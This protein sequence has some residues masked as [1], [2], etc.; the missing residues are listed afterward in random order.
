MSSQAKSKVQ[1]EVK[2]RR[3]RVA[4]EPCRE[5]KRKCNAEEP[6]NTCTHWDYDCYY[7]HEPRRKRIHQETP[8]EV[9]PGPSNTPGVVRR[10]EANSGAAFVH[11]MGLKIDPA[12]AP[13]LSLFGW[14]I[15][16]RPLSSQ[17]ANLTAATSITEITSL[18]HMKT[19]AKIY[20]DKLHPCY[21]FID[22]SQFFERLS[23]R[24]ES[25]LAS[26]LYDCVL[27]GVAALGCL[28]S[29]RD[30]TMT[31]THLVAFACS[32]L[33]LHVLTGVPPVD[34]LTGWTLRVIYMRMTDLPHATWMASSKL[35]HLIEAAGFHLESADSV[36]PR[37]NTT[38]CDP[39]IRRRLFGVAQ[40]LNMWT[41]YDLGLSR[42]SFQNND[43]PLLPSVKP[44]DFTHEVLGLLPV[45]ASL[46]PGKSKE[47][48]VDLEATLSKT[49]DRIH[50]EPPSVMAQCNL[51]LCILRRIHSQNFDISSQLAERVL[52]LF[53]RGLNCSRTMVTNCT[54]W[55]QMANVPFQIICVLLVM[56][57]RP[58]L[59]MLP[60]AMQT[61][62]LVASTYDTD[63]MK[64]ACKA[65]RLLVKL[66]QQ[67]RKDD[68]AI[69]NQSLE[70]EKQESPPEPSTQE[71]PS[72]EEY[73]WL[74]ALVADLPG[75]QKVDLDQFLNADMM[76]GSSL[77]GGSE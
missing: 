36:F 7:T 53:K 10:L 69:F 49:I 13:R 38:D 55:H 64:E 44:G 51:A 32:T 67:R 4:C 52:D 59:S 75:L 5:R 21:G 58:S 29:Q 71:N 30:M 39:D 72:S 27:G 15:G 56:D 24:W 18:G 28:F 46:D 37:S 70:L 9:T 48:E 26:G 40:H 57:T 2:R 16:K 11:K 74:G 65:A 77:L 1:S 17:I 35:M 25:P 50:N 33:E 34:L 22:R 20:F 6:C 43:L 60:E 66:H 14:N 23:A 73:S 31:E 41:S 47:D 54:P 68:I 61:L 62:N 8:V 12:K 76:D 42:V 63:S 45:S 3:A 19:L